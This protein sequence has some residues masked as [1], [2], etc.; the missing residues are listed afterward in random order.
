M[1]SQR[2]VNEALLDQSIECFPN[3]QKSPQD[4]RRL[5]YAMTGKSGIAP[6][7]QRGVGCAPWVPDTLLRATSKL[8][9]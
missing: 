1:A 5:S 2:V 3:R 8:W 4:V 9:N 7:L 6:I